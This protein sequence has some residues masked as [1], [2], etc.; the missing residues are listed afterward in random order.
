MGWNNLIVGSDEL[1]SLAKPYI[2]VVH[3]I[4]DFVKPAQP[5]NIIANETILTQDSIKQGLKVFGKKFEAA[6]WK[7]LQQFYDCRVV[8]PK[9]PQDL[10]Y[11]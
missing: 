4:D 3:A 9:K 2:N 1:H 11:E 6:V 8:E 5:T 7:E 10:S